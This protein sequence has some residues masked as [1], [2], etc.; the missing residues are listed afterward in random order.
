MEVA[1]IIKQAQTI[2]YKY[3]KSKK[4][5]QEFTNQYKTAVFHTTLLSTSWYSSR[6]LSTPLKLS[7][8]FLIYSLISTQTALPPGAPCTR[9]S[10]RYLLLGAILINMHIP[11]ARIRNPWYGIERY[12]PQHGASLLIVVSVDVV[13]RRRKW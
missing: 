8:I 1:K 6:T 4:Y 5:A 12:A 13:S 11:F 2:I 9:V 3:Q 7:S 10:K